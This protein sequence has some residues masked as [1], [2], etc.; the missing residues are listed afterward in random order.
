METKG[1]WRIVRAQGRIMFLA[2]SS[3]DFK[4]LYWTD[5]PK[6]SIPFPS[7]KRAN[8]W[9]SD[10]SMRGHLDSKDLA[11]SFFPDEIEFSDL[12]FNQSALDTPTLKD[13]RER[14]VRHQ[15]TYE[16]M[17]SEA[18]TP[19]DHENVQDFNEVIDAAQ[20]TYEAEKLAS[21]LNRIYAALNS[22]MVQDTLRRAVERTTDEA[23]LAENALNDISRHNTPEKP[24]TP[25]KYEEILAYQERLEKHTRYRNEAEGAMDCIVE[26]RHLI[27]A[28]FDHHKKVSTEYEPIAT[29]E[30]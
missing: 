19:T 5:D 2:R 18:E 20:R 11:Y 7:R 9:V 6:L 10:L 12:V 30:E 24:A 27:H 29:E 17:E 8:D 3:E 15:E 13:L 4:T 21:M 16:K 22:P 25:E 28:M 23:K 14:I 1:T 26:S